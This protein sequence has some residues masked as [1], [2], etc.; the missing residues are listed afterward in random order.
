MSW[1]KDFIY[2]F[3]PRTCCVCGTPLVDSEHEICVKCLMNLPEAKGAVG[4]ANFVEKRLMGRIPLTAATALLIFKK[5]NA[6]QRILHQ[7]KYRG[8][9]KLAITMGR[10]LGLLLA[11]DQRFSDVDLLVPIPLHKRKER[12]RGD[13]QSLL[14][15]KGIAQT[16]PRP[17]VSDN[18][19]RLRHTPSQ[20]NKN[21]QQRLENMKGVFSVIDTRQFE[22]KHMLLIDDVLTTGATTESCC[23][24]LTSI[25]DIRISVAVLAVTGDN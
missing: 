2:L 22:G 1:I 13:N 7:I 12:R 18:L 4:D 5:Q 19:I 17:I 6:T 16:F 15:C 11:N 24:A 23:L 21:R 10:Q 25:S 20:T 8:N 3:F 9:E 14:L